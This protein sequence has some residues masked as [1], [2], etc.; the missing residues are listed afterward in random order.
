MPPLGG[1]GLLLIVDFADA[2]AHKAL[3]EKAAKGPLL[4]GGIKK[5]GKK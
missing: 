3:R 2:A 5:S 4:G 1:Q